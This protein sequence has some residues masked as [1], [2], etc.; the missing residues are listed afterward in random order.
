M[1]AFTEADK[2]VIKDIIQEELP[3]STNKMCREVETLAKKIDSI[4]SRTWV[5]LVAIII[6][7]LIN[8]ALK[9]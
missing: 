2:A 4:D 5:I 7:T 9:F 8:I 6:G 3:C 1:T